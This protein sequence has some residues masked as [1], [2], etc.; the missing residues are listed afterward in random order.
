MIYIGF[1][2]ILFAVSLLTLMLF[3]SLMSKKFYIPIFSELVENLERDKDKKMFP[4][5]GAITVMAGAVLVIL[6]FGEHKDIV[7][8]S[9]IILAWG[10]SIAPL[11]GKY[12][13]I[14]HPTNRKK[15]LEGI[16]AGFFVAFLGAMFFVEWPYALL[17]SVNAMIIESFGF[18]DDNISMPLAAGATVWFLRLFIG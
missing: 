16:F 3:F 17:A 15:K 8:A 7:M 14:K 10:D 1:F 4:G 6:F 5:R 18:V 11:I 9:L 12:G 13:T 2:D